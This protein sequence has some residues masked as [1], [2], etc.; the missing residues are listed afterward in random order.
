MNYPLIEP[1]LPPRNSQF[2][3]RIVGTKPIPDT[4]SGN[5]CDLECGHRV[6]TFGSLSHTEGVVLCTQCRDKADET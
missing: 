6:M 2:H 4:K 1:D 5:Y 3:K